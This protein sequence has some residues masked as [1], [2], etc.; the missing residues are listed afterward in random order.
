MLAPY[1]PIVVLFA[2]A[3][4]F[5]LF[6]VIIAGI[7]AVTR[8]EF[9]RTPPSRTRLVEEPGSRTEVVRGADGE[10]DLHVSWFNP[11][12]DDVVRARPDCCDACRPTVIRALRS[13]QLR[14]DLDL[15]DDLLRWNG[16]D[17]PRVAAERV[18]REDGRTYLDR[19]TE[20]LRRWE[21][22]Q[23]PVPVAIG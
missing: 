11:D 12:V 2:L 22:E 9:H 5:S 18:A 8:I 20:V 3:F 6:S 10:F 15:L 14:F 21:D 17:C 7:V 13:I 19:I 16:C 4:G 23:R 1:M